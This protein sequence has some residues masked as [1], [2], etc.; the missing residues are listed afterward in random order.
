MRLSVKSLD[1]RAPI[2]PLETETAAKLVVIRPR[3]MGRACPAVHLSQG[4][5]IIIETDATTNRTPRY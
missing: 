1:R 5:I 2:W 4:D 3:G